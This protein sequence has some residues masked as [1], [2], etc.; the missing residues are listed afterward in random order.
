MILVFTPSL[1]IVFLARQVY[2]FWCVFVM[3]LILNCLI[4]G[5][6]GAMSDLVCEFIDGLLSPNATVHTTLGFGSPSAT[7]VMIA[8]WPTLT[9]TS[10]AR[11]TLAPT[12]SEEKTMIVAR[13]YV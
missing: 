9:W 8:S 7:H 2:F 11:I 5:A 12:R 13:F 4:T 1:M 10:S 6:T 3:P